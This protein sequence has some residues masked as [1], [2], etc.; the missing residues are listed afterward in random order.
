MAVSAKLDMNFADFY[1]ERYIENMANL[2]EIDPSRIKVVSVIPGSVVIDFIVLQDPKVLEASGIYDDIPESE[3]DETAFNDPADDPPEEDEDSSSNDDTT[4]SNDGTEAPAPAPPT[5]ES[6]QPAEGISNDFLAQMELQQ[7]EMAKAIEQQLDDIATSGQLQESLKETFGDDVSYMSLSTKVEEPAAGPSTSEDEQ[8]ESSSTKNIIVGGK[9]VSGKTPGASSDDDVPGWL[10]WAAVGVG[11]LFFAVV[12]LFVV[13]RRKRKRALM[14]SGGSAGVLKGQMAFKATRIGSAPTSRFGKLFSFRNKHLF[15]TTPAK[16]L[17]SH[18][19]SLESGNARGRQDDDM[20]LIEGAQETDDGLKVD[21][22]LM[23]IAVEEPPADLYH[24]DENPIYPEP[25]GKSEQTCRTP[26]LPDVVTISKPQD[27]AAPDVAP[28]APQALPEV[29]TK[30]KA[31][32]NSR[33]SNFK[34]LVMLGQAPAAYKSPVER[35]LDEIKREE[36][37]KARQEQ[38]AHWRREQSRNKM[39]DAVAGA[40]ADLEEEEMTAT[41]SKTPEQSGVVSTLNEAGEKE[42]VDV[43]NPTF[44]KTHSE[45]ADDDVRSR[46]YRAHVH[47]SRLG[48][49]EEMS[50]LPGSSMQD[51]SN[52]VFTRTDSEVSEDNRIAAKYAARASAVA[53][54]P[55]SIPEDSSKVA[56]YALESSSFSRDKIDDSVAQAMAELEEEGN[57]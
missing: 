10:I 1:E 25:A 39:E 13:D 27:P 31:N 56:K 8:T 24:R 14:M 38:E 28:S 47:N 49:V 3:V 15:E 6:S 46:T 11:V 57:L 16:P 52:P 43:D 54:R 55:I 19:I 12:S 5:E 41:S 48:K 29:V 30:K 4:S 37:R 35:A 40:L 17:E 20:G 2:L 22:P 34:S 32:I 44:A 51:V 21:N 53:S 50:S 36:E 9:V 45:V 26:A 18:E 23:V 7:A 42:F 33:D